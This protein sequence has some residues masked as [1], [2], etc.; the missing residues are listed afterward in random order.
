MPEEKTTSWWIHRQDI[1]ASVECIGPRNSRRAKSTFSVKYDCPSEAVLVRTH[2]FCCFSS[3]NLHERC[4]RLH[5]VD[6]TCRVLSNSTLD[7]LWKNARSKCLVPQLPSVNH[8]LAASILDCLIALLAR[9]IV[10]LLVATGTPPTD[11]MRLEAL[12]HFDD[13][14]FSS[15]LCGAFEYCIC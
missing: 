15:L 6:L 4:F 9:C 13:A 11:R 10:C 7:L 2:S 14:S 5:H 12:Y 3:R 8:F 1:I